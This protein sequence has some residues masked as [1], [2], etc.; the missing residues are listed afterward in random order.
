MA[1]HLYQIRIQR[2]ARKA[3]ERLPLNI[4]LR[5]ED[6]I[7]RLA[8][9][10]RPLGVKSLKGGNEYRIRVGDYRVIYLIYDNELLILVID[11]GHRKDV[12]RD[13]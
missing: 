5:V 13:I 6:A 10:P 7:M 8:A 11:A 3:I 12:Y 2:S 4:R 9:E 1:R